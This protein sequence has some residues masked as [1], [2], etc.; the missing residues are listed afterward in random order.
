M[1]AKGPS[2]CYSDPKTVSV[3]ERGVWIFFIKKK[4][5]IFRNKSIFHLNKG[6]AEDAGTVPIQREEPIRASPKPPLHPPIMWGWG[7]P[8]TR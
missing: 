7:R 3:Q 1:T 4:T 2:L 8:L 5:L 6:S